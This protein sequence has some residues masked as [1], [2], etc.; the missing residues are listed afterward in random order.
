MVKHYR[1]TVFGQITHMGYRFRTLHAARL[2]SITGTV[3]ETPE[4]LIIEAEGEETR[5][6]QLVSFFKE[7]PSPDPP[8]VIKIDEMPLRYFN[9]FTIT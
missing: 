7:L 2:L 5:L 4:G 9:E 6:K 8:M 1:I 3:A